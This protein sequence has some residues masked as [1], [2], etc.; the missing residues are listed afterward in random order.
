MRIEDHLK[1]L[2][3]RLLDPAIRRDPALVAPLIA[4][5]FIEFG[6]SGRVFDKASILED[7]KNE[8]PRPASRLT[9]FAVRELSPAII[10]ATYRATRFN[11]NGVAISQSHRSS[12]WAHS[13][14]QWQITFH[15]GT[16]I[17]PPQD[18]AGPP[19]K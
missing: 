1:Q 19:Q 12:I 18:P 13:D 7:L 10:L 6:A 2:E 5:D 16:P 17:P 14:G 11:A 15:Q 4:D 3:E 9:D 8:S